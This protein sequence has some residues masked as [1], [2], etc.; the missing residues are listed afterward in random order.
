[1]RLIYKE[2]VSSIGVKYGS[3]MVSWLVNNT[4]LVIQPV[5]VIGGG[6]VFWCKQKQRWPDRVV[7][8]DIRSSEYSFLLKERKI[9]LYF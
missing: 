2:R 8:K 9:K 7:D 3:S 4:S 6:I 1:M 5:H